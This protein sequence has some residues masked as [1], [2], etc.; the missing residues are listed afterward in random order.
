MNMAVNEK[1]IDILSD[2]LGPAARPFFA[3]QCKRVSKDPVEITLND[4]DEIATQMYDGI[5][6]VLGTELAEIVVRKIIAL[7]S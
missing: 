4:L 3:I 1:I 2:D 5:K 7:K 6:P